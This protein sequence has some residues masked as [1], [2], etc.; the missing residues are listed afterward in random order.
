MP[1]VTKV[2]SGGARILIQPATP[3]SF[4]LK[5][6]SSSLTQGHCSHMCPLTGIINFL[7]LLDLTSYS[8]FLLH[9]HT[10]SPDLTTPS[11]FYPYSLLSLTAKLLERFLSTPFLQFLPSLC[12]EP[13]LARFAILPTPLK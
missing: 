7:S 6:L 5:I 8:L 3:P 2:V 10:S 12:L 4:V 11:S 13:T 1:Q 9:T